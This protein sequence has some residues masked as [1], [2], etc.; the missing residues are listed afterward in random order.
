MSGRRTA[1]QVVTKTAMVLAALFLVSVLLAA[2]PGHHPPT[3]GPAENVG[4]TAAPAAPQ[5]D[6]DHSTMP[7]RAVPS[8]PSPSVAQASARA[9]SLASG[10][11]ESGR[12]RR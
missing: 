9:P 3:V 10:R 12:G 1:I 7:A 5:P 4:A 2:M 6:A 8:R 11:A